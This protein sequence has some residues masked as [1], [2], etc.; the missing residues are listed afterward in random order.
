MMRYKALKIV[1]ILIILQLCQFPQARLFEARDPSFYKDISELQDKV[2][3]RV[4]ILTRKDLQILDKYSKYIYDI[5]IY[6]RLNQDQL[7]GLFKAIELAL[8]L[9]L[10]P[11]PKLKQIRRMC[12]AATGFQFSK[13]II[14][15]I[16]NILW[17]LEV[18]GFDNQKDLLSFLELQIKK[19]GNENVIKTLIE[20]GLLEEKILWFKKSKIKNL[21]EKMLVSNRQN[22][23]I[24]SIENKGD[25]I[26]EIIISSYKDS[27]KNLFDDFQK[28]SELE[29]QHVNWLL[30]QLNRNKEIVEIKKLL[31]QLNKNW[32]DFHIKNNN[33]NSTESLSVEKIQE[34]ETYLNIKSKLRMIVNLSDIPKDTKK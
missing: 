6:E 29:S 13:R 32:L 22:E 9:N 27:I 21:S 34:I 5:K 2:N 30:L 12:I 7:K 26:Y 11:K 15:R 10:I 17:W 18:R 23:I 25:N 33:E 19:G 14:K 1:L 28:Y 16:R 31:V 4:L 8:E 3:F 20:L 24:H